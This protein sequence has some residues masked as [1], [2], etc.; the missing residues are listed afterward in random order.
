MQ[1]TCTCPTGSLKL[2]IATDCTRDQRLTTSLSPAMHV[3]IHILES[4]AR[5]CD[6]NSE[7]TMNAT[8]VSARKEFPTLH[9]ARVRTGLR[10]GHCLQYLHQWEVPAG[11]VE[12]MWVVARALRSLL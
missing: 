10:C 12:S 7:C 8:A 2:S 3:V 6:I 11:N 9:T 5:P 4:A 1:D